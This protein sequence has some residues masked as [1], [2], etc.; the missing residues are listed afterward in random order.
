MEIFKPV[1]GYGGRYSISNYGRVYSFISNRF[2]VV[3]KNCRG[4]GVVRLSMAGKTITKDVHRLV[5]TH[6]LKDYFEGAHVNHIDYDRLNNNVTNLEWLSQYDNNKYS[7]STRNS[8]IIKTLAKH[9][10]VTFPCGKTEIIYN[11]REFCRKN[12]LNSCNMSLVVNG[13]SKHHKGFN[14]EEVKG[15]KLS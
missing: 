1:E 15:V 10:L 13:K 9:Y 5:A 12:G 7:E 4:Y 3:S 6:F 2:M 14:A 8:S 11:M